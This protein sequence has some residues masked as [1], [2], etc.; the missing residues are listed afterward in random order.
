MSFSIFLA[1]AITFPDATFLLYFLI[2]I[3][4][5]WLAVFEVVL[6]VFQFI[7]GDLATKVMIGLALLN[8]ALFFFLTTRRPK[9][10]FHIN[11][12]R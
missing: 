10:I 4:A 9:H 8:V 1:Y 5:S 6:Y 11:D 2:P 3:K 12:Y 7:T